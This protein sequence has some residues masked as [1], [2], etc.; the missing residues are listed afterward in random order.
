MDLILNEEQRLLRDSAERFVADT[1]SSE[2]RQRMACSTEDQSGRFWKQ[3][4]DLGWLALSIPE[5]FGGLG[6]GTTELALLMEAFGRGLALSPFISTIVLG[7][8]LV[9]EA[10]DDAQRQ[11]MLPRV[12]AGELHLAFAFAERG[13]RFDLSDIA[14]RADRC[15]DGWR[16]SGRKIAVFDGPTA[17]QIIVTAR[18][19]SGIGLF[20]IDNGEVGCTRKDHARLGG[21]RSCD[22]ILEDVAVGTAALLG[23]REDARDV[24]DAVVDRALAVLCA[25][26][27]GMMD[28]VLRATVDYTKMR[29]QF[30]RPLSA[31]QAVRHCLADMAIACEEA[32]AITLR[33]VLSTDSSA[34]ERASAASAAKAKVGVGARFVAERAVQL[35]GGMGVTDELDIGLYLRRIVL[36]DTLFGGPAYHYQKLAQHVATDDALVA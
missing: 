1:F 5:A 23:G 25:E 29:H 13:K 36:F 12:A 14:T 19:P 2:V 4:A 21:G 30:G 33:A 26:A 3:F 16:L 32:R 27:V 28:A 34:P 35:H 7:A 15:S 18:T 8:A 11:D 20:V 24:I 31:N 22:L 10:G 6:A 9:A 17:S